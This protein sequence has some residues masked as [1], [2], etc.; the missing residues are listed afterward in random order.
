MTPDV[1]IVDP[2]LTYTMPK[3]C[4]HTGMDALT[5]CR[6]PRSTCASRSPTP[7]L[8]MA[9]ARSSSGC[10]SYAGDRGPSA[11]ARGSVHAG[12]AF[13]GLLG[14]VHSMAHK[15]GAALRTATSSTVLLTLYLGKV[16]Q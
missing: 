7:T 16:I 3:L 5:H 1:A 9:S 6:R 11:H 14:I 12:I 10:L 8:C 13:L 2:E 4:A 15:T